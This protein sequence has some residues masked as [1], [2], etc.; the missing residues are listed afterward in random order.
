M[1]SSFSG[2]AAVVLSIL[3]LAVPAM[4]GVVV[5]VPEPA[6]GLLAALGISAVMLMRGRNSKNPPK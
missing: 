4:A 6:T 1:K 3:C 2:L 5:P